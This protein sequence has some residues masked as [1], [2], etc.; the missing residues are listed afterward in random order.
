MTVDRYGTGKDFVV[1]EDDVVRKTS[2]KE[3]RIPLAASPHP[4]FGNTKLFN[5]L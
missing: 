4:T 2:F 1:Y 3:V 5:T